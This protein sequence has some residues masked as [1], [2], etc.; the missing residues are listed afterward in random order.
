MGSTFKLLITDLLLPF[1]YVIPVVLV[2]F[3]MKAKLEAM[4]KA[5]KAE[6]RR[7]ATKDREKARLE[8]RD[9]YY[10]EKKR[11]AAE[12]YRANR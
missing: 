9:E 12:R 1:W 6:A 7:Q 8:A 11:K 10:E 5:E 3:F 2:I 4:N